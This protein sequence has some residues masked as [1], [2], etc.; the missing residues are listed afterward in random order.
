VTRGTT[1]R[2]MIARDDGYV[3][4]PESCLSKNIREHGPMLVEDVNGWE[5]MDGWR[6]YESNS[7]CLHAFR[8]CA[9]QFEALYPNVK[10]ER[11]EWTWITITIREE[12][13]P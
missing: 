12:S 8:M 1:Q 9:Q 3:L 4:Y 7:M 10:L 2:F 6:V 5:E 13:K 11:H